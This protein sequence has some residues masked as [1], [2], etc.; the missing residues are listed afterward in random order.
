[1]TLTYYTILSSAGTYFS[2]V[3]FLLVS[4]LLV[5]LR[6]KA[7]LI[8]IIAAQYLLLEQSPRI[9]SCSTIE[10]KMKIEIMK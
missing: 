4:F 7:R 5:S 8:I 1:M 10:N 9:I 6:V 2:L 3:S